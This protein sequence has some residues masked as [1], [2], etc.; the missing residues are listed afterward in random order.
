MNLHQVH[1]ATAGDS[2]HLEPKPAKVLEHRDTIDLGK[3]DY[4]TDLNSSAIIFADD[5]PI[6]T[7]V[8][9]RED[10]EVLVIRKEWKRTKEKR[11]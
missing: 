8:P 4:F 9:V 6:K 1:Q 10:S 5:F 11:L 2:I 3:L 7:R